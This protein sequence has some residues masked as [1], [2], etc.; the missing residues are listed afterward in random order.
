MKVNMLRF[1]EENFLD[2]FV[3]TSVINDKNPVMI[4]IYS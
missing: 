3:A 1:D 4:F 2:L